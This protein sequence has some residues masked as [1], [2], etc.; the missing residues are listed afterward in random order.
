MKYIALGALLWVLTEGTG[1]SRSPRNYVDIGNQLLQQGKYADAELSYRKALQRDAKFGEAYYR[2]GLA[3]MRQGKLREAISALVQAVELSPKNDEARLTLTDICLT[4]YLENPNHPQVLYDRLNKLA[5]EYFKQDPASFDGYRIRGF[6]QMADGKNEESIRSFRKALERK[7]LNPDV[8]LALMKPLLLQSRLSEAEQIARASLEANPAFDQLYLA[9]YLHYLTLGRTAEAEN[10][11]KTWIANNP[12]NIEAAIQLC[13][14]YYKFKQYAEL[15]PAIEHIVSDPKKYPTGRLRVANFYARQANWKEAAT[16]LELGMQADQANPERKIVYQK[17]MI[18]VLLAQ[19]KMEEALPLAQAILAAHPEDTAA[20]DL[21]GSLAMTQSKPESLAAAEKDFQLL[22]KLDP[23]NAVYRFKL[24]R[25]YHMKRDTNSARRLYQESSKM[26][27]SY[28]PPRMGLAEISF[29]EKQYKDAQTQLTSILSYDPRN[30]EVRLMMAATL[31]GLNENNKAH[32]E[33][34]RL[35]QEFPRYAAAQVQ[36]GYLYLNQ[37]QYQQAEA[38]FQKNYTPGQ[39]DIRPLNGLAEIQMANGKADAALNLIRLDMGRSPGSNA[40]RNLMV[41]MAVRAGQYNLAIEQFQPIFD[42]RQDAASVQARMGDLYRLAGKPE[43]AL[44]YFDKAVTL[45]P[46]EPGPG[47]MAAYILARLGRFQEA[48]TRYQQLLKQRPDDPLI[49]NNFAS[50]LAE[51]GT[52]LDDAMRYAQR[53]LQSNP[54]DPQLKD[55]VGWIY[56]KRNDTNAALQIL[57]NLAKQYPNSSTYRYHLGY[58]FAQ[59]GDK[60]QAK[61]HLNSALSSQPSKDEETKIRQL[62]ATLG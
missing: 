13:T 11:L 54:S 32:D 45:S 4:A 24:G 58:A 15:T 51:A 2:L 43:R 59:K 56:A 50:V 61:T 31:M 40:A 33:L 8:S 5:E 21:R 26:R 37:K 35:V 36:L 57:S 38:L 28:L 47:I 34:M 12:T 16:Q 46:S 44:T 17:E 6:L 18:R 14:H 62:L 19:N 39:S 3:A 60:A 10:L 48:K 55:T 42:A 29:D 30:P 9:L 22:V 25:I 20:L 49:L 52:N 1:C 7:P 23:N 27:A 53:A 41:S